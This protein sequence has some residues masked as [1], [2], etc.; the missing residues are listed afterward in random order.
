MNFW[1]LNMT[2][3]KSFL[4]I[5]SLLFITLFVGGSLIISKNLAI[6]SSS[7][8]IEQKVIPVLNR[9]HE[10][11]LAVV[12]VQQWLTD[13]SATQGK[14]GLD[15]GFD[16]AEYNAQRFKTL[17]TELKN[18]GSENSANYD[19]M[20]PIFDAYYRDGQKMAHAYIEQ[21]PKGG[22]VIM[23]EFDQTAAKMSEAVDDFL[24]EIES[25]SHDELVKLN[26]ASSAVTY[27]SATV[28]LIFF[29]VVVALYFAVSYMLTALGG[30]SKVI[31]IIAKGDLSSPLDCNK[32]G[33][34][35]EL[36]LNVEQ[37]RCSLNNMISKM[38]LAALDLKKEAQILAENAHQANNNIQLQQQDVVHVMTAIEQMTSSTLDM[39][40]STH[41]VAEESENAA[42]KS[43]EGVAILEQ[44]LLSIK[45]LTS[46]VNETTNNVQILQGNSNKIDSVLTVI[47]DITEQTNLLALNAAIEAARAGEA[48]RGFAVVADEVRK[49][50]KRTQDSAL[51]IQTM[52]SAIKNSAYAVHQAMSIST[53]RAGTTSN[54]SE[55]TQQVFDEI[56]TLIANIDEQISLIERSSEEQTQVFDGINKEVI[57]INE[58]S[59]DNAENSEQ[60]L[61]IS[62]KVAKS[63]QVISEFGQLFKI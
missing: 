12:Q 50:A 34:I 6:Q 28:F 27:S 29:L 59:I 16:E 31:A 49:L 11:K 53:Q 24:L 63:A 54:L 52:T 36:Y 61:Q 47:Q 18:L 62:Q 46:S 33:E 21:G 60:L 9:A 58:I 15:D 20:L 19:S 57:H 35:G 43:K 10:L 39:A 55:N 44:N 2:I 48:G 13:I 41:Y 51:E 40:K 17:I 22:N 37:M 25:R 26:D 4:L 7:Q 38:N 42:K 8:H 3:R 14:D 1:G 30:I 23:G 5:N 32:G 45:E 56:S